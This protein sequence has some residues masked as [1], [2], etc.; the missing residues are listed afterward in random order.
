MTHAGGNDRG[1]PTWLIAGLIIAVIGIALSIYSTRHHLAVKATGKTDAVCNINEQF[2]CDDV[3]LSKFSEIGGIPLGV[4]GLGYFVASGVLLL[5]GLRGGKPA[6]EHM[7]GYVAMVLI[8]VLTSVGLAIISTTQIGAF[9]V[10]CIGVYVLTGLQAATLVVWR[11]DLPGGFTPKNVVSGGTTAVIAVAAVILFFNFA[12][13]SLAPAPQ[14]GNTPKDLENMPTLAANAQEVPVSKS[15]YSGLGEDYRKGGDNAKV[16]INEFADFQC[17]ACARISETLSSLH[18]EYGDRVLIVFRNYPLDSSCN[19]AVQARIHESACG[20]AVMARCAGQYGKFWAF[21]DMAFGLQ[22]EMSAQ[23]LRQWGAQVGLTN[24][25]MD[26][27]MA[28]KDIMEKV[29]SDIA[30]GN[31]LGVDSTPTLFING[32][33]VLGGRGVS[34]LKNEID[35]LLN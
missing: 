28:S 26:Q 1:K 4:F 2:S 3:A 25:Q 10:T 8:G 13:S 34:E 6:R 11:K 21:H 17:P 30:L 20:A 14:S 16:V 35:Q 7:Q 12:K 9:C 24:E 22:K 32:R 15:A 27:C 19:S 31:Q 29:K 5:I 18:K 23:S 33:K